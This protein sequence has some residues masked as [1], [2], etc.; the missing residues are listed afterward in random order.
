MEHFNNDYYLNWT[1]GPIHILGL[2]ICKT[3][4][5]SI[6]YNFEP[7]MKTI[8]TIFNMWKQRNLFLKGKIT[9]YP[10]SALVDDISHYLVRCLPVSR[11]WESFVAW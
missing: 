1:D 11:Y 10:C 2:H 8:R 9:V 7:R 4:V 6:K 3:E 5:E